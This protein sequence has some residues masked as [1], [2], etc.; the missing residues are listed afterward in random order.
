MKVCVEGLISC[1]VVVFSRLIMGWGIGV[2]VGVMHDICIVKLAESGSKMK[3]R[4]L[5]R[6]FSLYE[7]AVLTG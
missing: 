6:F 7:C 5:G 4:S 3:N 1:E 2:M